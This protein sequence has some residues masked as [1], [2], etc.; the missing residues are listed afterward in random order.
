MKIDGHKVINLIIQPDVKPYATENTLFMPPYY[1]ARLPW[2]QLMGK[3]W[4]KKIENWL[5]LIFQD[6]FKNHVLVSDLSNAGAPGV[7]A[8][9]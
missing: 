9:R 4:K 6:L 2:G 1:Y 8:G 3:Y 7:M 5:V